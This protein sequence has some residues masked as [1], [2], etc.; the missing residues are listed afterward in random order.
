MRTDRRTDMHEA[1]SIFSQL[2]EGAWQ[3]ETRNLCLGLHI[4]TLRKP[5][6]LKQNVLAVHQK[7]RSNWHALCGC[8]FHRH[9]HRTGM[10]VQKNPWRTENLPFG[11]FFAVPLDTNKT[12]QRKNLETKTFAI[13]TDHKKWVLQSCT[14]CLLTPIFFVSF[15]STSD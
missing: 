15:E 7:I 12:F 6:W 4:N 5:K 9:S 3:K 13:L 11:R 2:C 14:I 10:R 1:N 8:D